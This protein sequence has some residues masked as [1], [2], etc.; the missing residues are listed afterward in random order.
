M[1]IKQENLMSKSISHSQSFSETNRDV[2]SAGSYNNNRINSGESS[3]SYSS[4][5]TQNNSNNRKISNY[6][7]SLMN[8]TYDEQEAQESFKKA[9]LEWR[10]SNKNASTS[11]KTG[12]SVRINM[13][14]KETPLISSRADAN[15]GSDQKDLNYK[16]I[17]SL[18]NTN[19][20]LSYAE[21]MLLRKNRRNE[22]D[23]SLDSNN[24]DQDSRMSVNISSVDY[25]NDNGSERM[26]F[27]DIMAAVNPDE[28]QRTDSYHSNNLRLDLTLKIEE[29]ETSNSIVKPKKFNERLLTPDIIE[30]KP[31]QSIKIQYT[32][33]RSN[34][35]IKLNKD[36][37][38]DE[39]PKSTRLLNSARV[40]S[41]RKEK[42]INNPLTDA[43]SKME[44]NL[45]RVASPRLRAVTE[46]K[47]DMYLNENNLNG[48]GEF[49]LMDVIDKEIKQPKSSRPSSS[50]ANSNNK[51]SFKC[52]II[53]SKI[54]FYC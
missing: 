7:N 27:K 35:M 6:S 28:I 29:L 8:G 12:K 20:S 43:L 18:V 9:V 16:T 48:V 31:N 45:T 39:I 23:F 46:R 52:K 14:P 13:T 54:L 26:N 36:N 11:N 32:N 42:P 4:N 30:T 2:N 10:N 33:S 21:R 44:S 40:K 3:S 49:I 34:S 5:I 22:L 50:Q 53:C 17:E 25:I 47:I 24:R 1:P 37:L 15:V 38:D 41:A 51:L 19:H